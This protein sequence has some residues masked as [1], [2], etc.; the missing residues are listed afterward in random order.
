M[1]NSSFKSFAALAAHVNAVAIA[2]NREDV[3]KANNLRRSSSIARKAKGTGPRI[4]R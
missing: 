2:Q 3:R 4:A 1:P